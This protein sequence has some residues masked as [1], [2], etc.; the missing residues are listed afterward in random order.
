MRFTQ[1]LI[2]KGL[3][4]NPI[5]GRKTLCELY[6][7]DLYYDAT[8]LWL[9]LG[10]WPALTEQRAL[11]VLVNN[12]GARTKGSQSQRELLHSCQRA[13]LSIYIGGET[14]ISRLLIKMV[15]ALTFAHNGTLES[16]AV[17]SRNSRK[18]VRLGH[19]VNHLQ[20]AQS[21]YTFSM[22]TTG[23]QAE[24]TRECIREKHSPM[25]SNQGSKTQQQTNKTDKQTSKKTNPENKTASPL[26]GYSS[27]C[28]PKFNYHP[29]AV[30]LFCFP[31]WE[32]KLK[33]HKGRL[34]I[35]SWTVQN[36]KVAGVG[37]T[38]TVYHLSY[39]TTKAA[40]FLSWR[41]ITVILHTAIQRSPFA[42]K[43]ISCLRFSTF[44]VT[45]ATFTRLKS[46]RCGCRD[47]DHLSLLS[48]LSRLNSNWFTS[49]FLH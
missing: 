41:H 28:P 26:I 5:Q 3:E 11:H 8:L 9:R 44:T 32:V 2:V 35:G 6:K 16:E 24:S 19:K 38:C 37:P 15:H 27:E 17:G 36:V 23:K 20:G 14:N 4:A 48:W 25:H 1:R 10:Y 31:G 43:H 7:V 12:S 39:I 46:D 49:T 40:N 22:W 42:C 18:D 13:T 47:R 45:H 29:S 34:F 30:L 21:L 33:A